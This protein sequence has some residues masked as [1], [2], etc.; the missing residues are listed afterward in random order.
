[1]RGDMI[2]IRTVAGQPR[3]GDDRQAGAF[4]GVVQGQPVGGL[5]GGHQ[6]SSG[7][8]FRSDNIWCGVA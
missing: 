7:M 2:E 8:V 6:V 1:M 5:K 3:Q 4:V